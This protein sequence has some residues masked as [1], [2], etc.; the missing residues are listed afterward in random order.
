M[1]GGTVVLLAAGGGV[2]AA[3]KA[4]SGGDGDSAKQGIGSAAVA[5]GAGKSPQPSKKPKPGTTTGPTTAPTTA[6]PTTPPAVDK[7][8]VRI[9]MAG[10][11]TGFYSG[12]VV[13]DAAHGKV[14]LTA[15]KNTKDVVA[16]DLD[17]GNPHSIAQVDG[18]AG[19][20][21]SPDGS[22]L[23]VA[24][25]AGSWVSVI[26]TTTYET[27]GYWIG[28]TDGTNTCP[29]DVALTAGQLWVAWG[30]DNAPAGVG[31]IDLE[32]RHY[33][34]NVTVGDGSVRNLVSS[35]ALLATVP[36]QPN[37]LLVGE[38]DSLPAPL[39]RFE[40]EDN[41]LVL[42]ATGTTDGGAVAQLAVT[43]DG[44][45]VIVPS[46]APYYHQVF[47]TSDLTP[48]GRY[49]TT[50]YP[51]AVAIRD[52]G[53]VVAG[54]NGSYEDDL[55]IFR[56]GGTEPILTYEFGHLPNDVT[57]AYH[58][59]DGALALHGNRVYALTDQLSE[60]GMLTLRIRELPE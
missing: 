29:R 12:D 57:W 22:K 41:L 26:D 58:L 53:L 9:P 4:R 56:P 36:G 47:R 59:Q 48:A 33:E 44:S 32:T 8:N 5:K 51:N 34:L 28:R 20:T 55:W 30:C 3:A 52:D 23:Y 21:L 50:S 27:T 40:I 1:A 16:T 45:E 42:K 17:G 37:V 31:R 39:Y 13:V 35:P 25:S 60:P 43:P 10:Y 14:Y 11:E 7:D 46:G 49:Q 54:V 18:G 6:P 2:A 38:T 15:G 19:M 24:A